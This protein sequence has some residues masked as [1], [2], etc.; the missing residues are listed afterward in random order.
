MFFYSNKKIFIST[1]NKISHPPSWPVSTGASQQTFE[2]KPDDRVSAVPPDESVEVAVV[3]RSPEAGFLQ[4]LPA[5]CRS[6]RCR[7]TDMWPSFGNHPKSCPLYAGQ[8]VHGNNMLAGMRIR[9]HVNYVKLATCSWNV[10]NKNIRIICTCCV[11]CPDNANVWREICFHISQSKKAKFVCWWFRA[12]YMWIM[13]V[14]ACKHFFAILYVKK[15][16]QS[17]L[18]NIYS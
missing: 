7:S 16:I 5:P 1:S 12:M 10:W 8:A 11:L 2:Q 4:V 3:C 15:I 18:R 9:W 6:A 14:N 17:S 13:R